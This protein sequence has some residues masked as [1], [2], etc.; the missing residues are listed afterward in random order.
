MERAHSSTLGL[1]GV[2]EEFGE[3]AGVVFIIEALLVQVAID[4]G[5]MAVAF[6]EHE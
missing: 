6:R 3:M 1:V 2:V 4:A 5:S